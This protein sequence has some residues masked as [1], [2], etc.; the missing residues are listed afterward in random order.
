MAV[1][2]LS[3][4]NPFGYHLTNGTR[5]VNIIVGH[6][7]KMKERE[8]RTTF[9]LYRDI[10]K[11]IGKSNIKFGVCRISRLVY[12]ANSN[13]KEMN[14]RILPKLRFLLPW[15]KKKSRQFQK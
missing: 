9:E 11:V 12:G 10:I 8:H 3:G 5:E 6:S 13:F 7:D 2:S 15:L 14:K 1:Y 4:E